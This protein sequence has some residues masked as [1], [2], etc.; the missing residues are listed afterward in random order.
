MIAK[1]IANTHVITKGLL[2]G[3]GIIDLL[4]NQLQKREKLLITLHHRADPLN[5]KRHA[6]VSLVS[7]SAA[8]DG[9]VPNLRGCHERIIRLS[10]K[11]LPLAYG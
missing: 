7:S 3:S 2:N 8:E 5:T 10:W 11:H 1:G 6:A 4:F 9:P